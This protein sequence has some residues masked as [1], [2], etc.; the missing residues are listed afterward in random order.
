MA[1]PAVIMCRGV[2]LTVA[3]HVLHRAPLLLN[4]VE[5]ADE[6]AVIELDRDPGALKMILE[7][8]TT[9]NIA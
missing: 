4:V 1:S 2:E 9:G 8:C 7:Y 5:A 6:A 3:R